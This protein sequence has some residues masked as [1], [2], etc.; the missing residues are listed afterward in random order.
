MIRVFLAGITI[1][2]SC[3]GA[4]AAV[5]EHWTCQTKIGAKPYTQEWMVADNIMFAPKAT[6]NISLI[7]NTDQLAVGYALSQKNDPTVSY[8]FILD[9]H[10]GK[11]IEYNDST[12]AAVKG[13]WGELKPDIQISPCKRLD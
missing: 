12:A 6:K 1:G 10:A 5:V 13:A 8:I 3:I 2:A 4:R 9:K 11:F 7:Y